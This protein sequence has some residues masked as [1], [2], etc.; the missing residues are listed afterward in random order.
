MLWSWAKRLDHH[1]TVDQ[2]WPY[3]SINSANKLLFFSQREKVELV[4]QT[5]MSRLTKFSLIGKQSSWKFNAHPHSFTLTR[6][7]QH[8]SDSWIYY[9]FLNNHL[10]IG[11]TLFSFSLTFNWTGRALPTPPRC[12]S[13]KKENKYELD[14]TFQFEIQSKNWTNVL[15]TSFPL[16]PCHRFTAPSSVHMDRTFP[17]RLLWHR[18]N[19]LMVELP[20]LYTGFPR[21]LKKS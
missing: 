17:W 16:L 8:A 4:C 19:T 20:L 5:V 10:Y 6:S 13:F 2:H 7:W 12:P 1:W 21:G 3:S 14:L 11:K 18:I 9:K 15:I